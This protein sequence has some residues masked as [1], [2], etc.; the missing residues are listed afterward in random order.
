ME[1]LREG[2][3]RPLRVRKWEEKGDVSEYPG[4]T[5]LEGPLELVFREP[6]FP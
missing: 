2:L 5:D 4:R 1:V 6:S 3:V